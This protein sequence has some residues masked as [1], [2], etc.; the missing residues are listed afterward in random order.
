M[1]GN[2][3]LSVDFS[4]VRGKRLLIALSGGADS[5]ALAC[6]LADARQA[7]ELDLAAAHLDHGIRPDSAEDAACCR[8]LCA[9][10][11]IPFRTLRL[12]VPAEAARSGEGLETSARRLRYAWLRRVKEEI[13]ADF[14]ALAHHMDDQAE[15]VLMHLARGAG[16]EGVCGMRAFSG[17]LYRPLLGLRKRDLM[18]YLVARGVSWREDST[19]A[20]ADT[21]RNAL[22]LHGI[23]ALEQ[24]YPQAVPAIA[25]FAQ[26]AQVESDYVREQTEFYIQHHAVSLPSGTCLGL[27]SGLHP[28][29]LRRALRVCSHEALDWAH[30]NAAAQLASASRGRQ[31]L[32]GGYIAERGRCGLYLLHSR[33]KSVP[34]VPL[35]LEGETILPE[36]CT[37]SA[38]PCDPVPLRDDP[39]RQ[40]LNPAA[41]AGAVVRTRRP[42]DRFRPLGCGDR[43]LSDFLTDRRI[44]RPLRDCLALVARGS[45]VLWVCGAGISEDVKLTKGDQAVRLECRYSFDMR[46][47]LK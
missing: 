3:S 37:L 4:A 34:E 5:V 31:E 28:A 9:R 42:G 2:H 39:M 30:L 14:I 38:R 7:C 43:L 10:L 44:D 23:P 41:L 24:S 21:P 32:G 26:S 19:N 45:R 1:R 36:I 8:E 15:T 11:G 35:S 27:F 17:D 25:R 22:R 6:L 13:G 20:L 40:A 46:R 12:D 18:K 47:L 16:P 29:I 33:P